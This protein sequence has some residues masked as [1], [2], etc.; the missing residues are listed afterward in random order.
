MIFIVLKRLVEIFVTES[1]GTFFN[2]FNKCFL[3]S[4]TALTYFNVI[5]D[6]VLL[7]TNCCIRRERRYHLSR[8]CVVHINEEDCFYLQIYKQQQQFDRFD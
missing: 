4:T 1:D 7:K 8:G 2:R 3:V 5:L 6:L